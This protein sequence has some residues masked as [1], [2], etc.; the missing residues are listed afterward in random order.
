MPNQKRTNIHLNNLYSIYKIEPT[1][2]DDIRTNQ[3]YSQDLL[4]KSVEEA[5]DKDLFPSK[6]NLGENQ[7]YQGSD[8]QLRIYETLEFKDP[9][10]TRYIIQN[11]GSYD[12]FLRMNKI[13][14]TTHETFDP[15]FDFRA[16]VTVITSQKNLKSDHISAMELIMEA[17]T[18]ICTV[19]YL[20]KTG[21]SKRLMGSLNQSVLPPNKSPE[22]F[23]FFGPLPGNR[24]ALFNLVKKDWSSFYMTN[25]I[26]FVRDDTIGIE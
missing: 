18:G 9:A 21:N 8:E 3:Q 26:R 6:F 23:N 14:R 12:N 22:R 15:R 5:M 7:K 24:I 13:H 20:D 10:Y 16:D 17:L 2:P 4:S 11:Y 25:L 19:D 1:Q